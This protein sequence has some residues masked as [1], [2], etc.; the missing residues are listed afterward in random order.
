MK[1]IIT[2]L[3]VIA[4]VVF[5]KKRNPKKQS[6]KRDKTVWKPQPAQTPKSVPTATPIP[7]SPGTQMP[8]SLM[9]E[10]KRR[11]NKHLK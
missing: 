3:V 8:E 2:I 6:T 9:E 4:I 7:D 1:V 10:P 11:G 5:L